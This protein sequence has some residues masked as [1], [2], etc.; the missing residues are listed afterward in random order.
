MQI[1]K[2]NALRMPE[3]VN[4]IFS[5]TSLASKAGNNVEAFALVR[6]ALTLGTMM[7]TS[8]ATFASVTLR[9]A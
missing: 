9:A 3:N 6:H 8:L 1:M 2:A 4:V 7:D 5:L